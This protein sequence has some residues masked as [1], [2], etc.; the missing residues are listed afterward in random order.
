MARIQIADLPPLHDIPTDEELAKLFGAGTRRFQPTLEALEDR[1]L[2]SG[3]PW[4]SGLQLN[5][6]LARQYSERQIQWAPSQGPRFNLE[7]ANQRFVDWVYKDLFHRA[8]TS[9][10]LWGEGAKLDNGTISRQDWL[11]NLVRSPAYRTV[12]ANDLFNKYLHRDM[13][14]D[15]RADGAPLA[16]DI[17]AFITSDAGGYTRERLASDIVS[18]DEYWNNAGGTF[19]G[20]VNAFKSDTGNWAVDTGAVLNTFFDFGQD[21]VVEFSSRALG[22]GGHSQGYREEIYQSLWQ[23]YRQAEA[24]HGFETFLG[25]EPSDADL[26]QQAPANAPSLPDEAYVLLFLNTREYFDHAQTRTM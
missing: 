16:P 24:R 7:S 1:Q 4:L 18:S 22:W 19:E 17:N 11:T 5:P 6:A 2:L 9:D 26:A 15:D 8:A 14:P 12:V 25:R 3:S 21:Q 20:W 23:G 13:T 10:E